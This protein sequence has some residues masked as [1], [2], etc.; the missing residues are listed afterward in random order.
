MD[1]IEPTTFYMIATEFAQFGPYGPYVDLQHAILATELVRAIYLNADVDIKT[2][3]ISENSTSV[4]GLDHIR[5][6]IKLEY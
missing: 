5:D 1:N 2:I 3:T 4:C 6:V